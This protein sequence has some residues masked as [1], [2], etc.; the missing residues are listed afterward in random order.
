MTKEQLALPLAAIGTVI[1]AALAAA[2]A[3]LAP[4]RLGQALIGGLALPLMWT[5]V[6]L[7]IKGDKSRPRAALAATALILAMF[8]G[9]RVAQAAR[10]LGPDDIRLGIAMAGMVSG[11]VLAYFG[12]RVP[13]I[14]ER[15]NPEIDFGK[16]QAFLRQAGWI[17]VLAGLA[18]A[19][20]WLLLPVEDAV[21]W[22]SLV[23]GASTLL[24][25]GRTLQ[26]WLQGRRA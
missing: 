2:W 9:M 13:K 26:C 7:A 1:V 17:F 5:A 23:V 12:N 4:H 15:F 21:L 20:I 16:R 14:L 25:I 8:L 19:L 24:V 22:A 3:L 11:L 18:S 10:W 6:E